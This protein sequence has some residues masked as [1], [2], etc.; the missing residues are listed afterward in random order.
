[1]D[2]NLIEDNQTVEPEKFDL[3]SHDIAEDKRRE[4]LSLFPE[5]RTENGKL[6]FDRLKL[7][8]GES[9]DIGKERYG[10][11]W[12]GKADCFRTIQMPSL[13]TLRPCPEESVNFD[14]TENLI[15]EGDNLEVLKLLQKSYLGKVKMIYI[16]PPYNTGNDF[17]YPDN[18]SESLQTYLEYTG[19]V[20]AEGRK[21]GTNTDTDGRFHSKWLNMMYPRLYLARNLLREDGVIF[22]SIDDNE[23]DNLRKLCNEIFGEENF[24]ACLIWKKM[25]SPSRNDASRPTSDFH[26]YILLYAR[27]KEVARFRQKR[28]PGILDAYPISLP[29]G[30]LV[31]RRQLR[32]NGKNARRVDRPTMW[33][34]LI[35][36]DGTEVWPT[37]PEGWEGRW[38]LS[39]ETWEEREAAGM[40]DWFKRKYGWVPYYI[41]VAPDE[42]SVPWPT[43][44]TE[45]DQ[46]RQAKARFTE[47]MGPGVEFDNPKPPNL[48]IEM[49]RMA[50]EA[51]D[52]VLDFFAGS[53]V[54]GEAVLLANNQDGGNRR[55]LLVQLPEPT[56]H[57]EYRTVADIC[58]ERVRRTIR[59]FNFEN[60]GMFDED[61][62]TEQD[63][64]F[65]TFRLAESNFKVWEAEGPKDAE[66]LAQQLELHVE[67]IREGRTADDL[68][69]ELLLKSG[70]P[71]TTPV[72]IVSVL[73]QTLYSIAGG[74]FI[75]CLE[76]E[77]TLDLIRA[78]AEKKPERVVL[79]DEGFAGNDQLKSNAVQ[80][81][82]TKGITSF[83]T[84]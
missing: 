32:K 77:L 7:A 44:W 26:D 58:K 20:D 63:C 34:P 48:I 69:Y 50:T 75:I 8:L 74:L 72:E 73:G 23:V 21:F 53:G 13:A 62:N 6:D 33:F 54:T 36:P 70:F 56:G 22:V 19:Q 38:V 5:I 29:D 61:N 57:T 12:P 1:M 28:K 49:L 45:V 60:S 9:V 55:F 43:L 52:I 51:E 2:E 47:L 15:I 59:Q 41:E 68:L 39:K 71:L 82:K 42:P 67:H 24:V 46:N 17:I 40:T 35:A 31:R 83:K 30:R 10:M 80:I 16:D 4:L 37:A 78:I 14:T 84:V 65:R 79:L 18:Y 25:D 81:F 76:R 11:N 66:S 27:N 64:G 3:R